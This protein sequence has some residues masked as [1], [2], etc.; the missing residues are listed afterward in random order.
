MPSVVFHSYPGQFHQEIAGRKGYP[1]NKYQS[2]SERL[3]NNCQ[4]NTAAH[5]LN[6]FSQLHHQRKIAARSGRWLPVLLAQFRRNG[7]KQKSLQDHGSSPRGSKPGGE[8]QRK[9]RHLI[10]FP[11]RHFQ[12]RYLANNC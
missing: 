12:P 1:T 4:T 7:K 11:P 6:I 10:N 8:L 9:N 5:N 2:Q 3:K